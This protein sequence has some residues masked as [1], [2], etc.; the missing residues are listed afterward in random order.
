MS[1][2]DPVADMLTRIRNAG[3]ARLEKVEIPASKLKVRIAQILQEVGFVSGYRV[4]EDSRQ[5]MLYV[6]LRYDDERRLAIREIKRLS[7]P[8]RRVYASCDEIPRIRNGLGVCIVSTSQG[9]MT[10]QEARHKRVGGE[11]LCSVW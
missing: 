11:L 7:K 6:D 3:M 8:G 1:M 2:T 5:G 10:D 4:V 9:V